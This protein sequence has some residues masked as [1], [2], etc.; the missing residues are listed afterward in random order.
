MLLVRDTR[1]TRLPTPEGSD[2]LAR[3]WRESVSIVCFRLARHAF[4]FSAGC[5]DFW[6]RR[7][8]SSPLVMKIREVRRQL[9]RYRTTR[10]NPAA[11]GPP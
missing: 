8:T 11:V 7:I 2:T 9:P 6:S 5:V 1:E 10:I 3:V 4:S